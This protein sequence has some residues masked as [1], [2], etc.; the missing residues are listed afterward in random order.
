MVN[1]ASI[2]NYVSNKKTFGKEN[3]Y[4]TRRSEDFSH[5]KLDHRI[6]L[7]NLGGLKKNWYSGEVEGLSQDASTF[8]DDLMTVAS[9]IGFSTEGMHGAASGQ[10]DSGIK[11]NFYYRE[12]ST[13]KLC[14]LLE[15]KAFQNGNLHLKL[16]QK[17]I[18]AINCEFGRLKGW[19]KSREEAASELDEDYKDTVFFG[20]NMQFVAGDIIPRLGFSEAA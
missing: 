14:T 16:N 15:V 18:C 6:I 17:F 19:L 3:W 13:G 2:V 4:Y 9:N 5:Y 20:V 1:A 11:N 10:W 8:I 12:P 7:S